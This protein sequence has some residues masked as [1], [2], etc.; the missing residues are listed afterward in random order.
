MNFIFALADIIIVQRTVRQWLA[1]KELKLLKKGMR[2]TKIQAFWR[3]YK[4]R[5]MMLYDLV[6]IIIVQVSGVE[7]LGTVAL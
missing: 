5:E 7:R 3:G 1:M 4:A 2:A 6:D